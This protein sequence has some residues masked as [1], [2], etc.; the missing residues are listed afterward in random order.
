MATTQSIESIVN[1]ERVNIHRVVRGSKLGKHITKNIL[2]P[3]LVEVNKTLD[4][5]IDWVGFLMQ[6][7]IHYLL[8]TASPGYVYEV[9]YVD[10]D[11][12]YGQ[13]TTPI[14]TYEASAKGGP[15]KS[16][17]GGGGELP[18]SGSLYR[19]VV[20][21]IEGN[22][23]TLGI[24][25]ITPPYKLWY[26]WG[27]LFQ[28]ADDSE[29]APGDTS[30]YGLALDNPSMIDRGGKEQKERG[31]PYRPYWRSGIDKIKP[32]LKKRFREEFSKSLQTI[33]RR[34]TVRRALQIRFVWE[35][36]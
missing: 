36:K 7:E 17:K 22:T 9:Y 5:I 35:S 20:Y 12:P 11:M 8:S 23:I 21:A 4:E 6:D 19:S 27:K 10:P 18:Q 16:P 1:R 14:G 2:E 28:F 25:S 13:K 33:T 24:K 30:V 31:W 3:I 29:L 15:P 32:K 34:P 26:G